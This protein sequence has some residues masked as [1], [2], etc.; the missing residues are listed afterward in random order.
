[1]IAPTHR[2]PTLNALLLIVA[3][4]A[5]VVALAFVTST[6]STLDWYSAPAAFLLVASIA[7]FPWW[8]AYLSRRSTSANLVLVVGAAFVAMLAAVLQSQRRP[9][10]RG[11]SDPDAPTGPDPASIL[12]VGVIAFLVTLAAAWIS[13]WLLDRGHPILAVISSVIA[14]L[15]VILPPMVIFTT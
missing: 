5:I 9:S 1:M 6:S 7:L 4:I 2:I 15:A 12:T 10:G 3:A 8:L 14:G 13:R 11:R